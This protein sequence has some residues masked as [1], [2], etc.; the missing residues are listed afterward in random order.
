VTGGYVYRGEAIPEL[1]GS[2]F[3]GD[4]CSGMVASFRQDAEG[5]FDMRD[6]TGALGPVPGLTS[7]GV[8]GS[9]ELYLVALSGEIYRLERA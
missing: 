7:F 1:A 5:L 3:Y 2:Y 8:D 6:W 4:F 9:G